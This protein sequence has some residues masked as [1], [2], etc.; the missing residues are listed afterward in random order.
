MEETLKD[1]HK[2]SA[3][4][5]AAL[6][7]SKEISSTELTQA[8]LARIRER[9]P[10][11]RAWRHID[12]DLALR[13]AAAADKAAARTPL[14]GIP[15]GVKDVIDTQDL[16]TEYGS[17]VHLGR[18][19]KA[20]AVCVAR[21]RAAGA[22]LLGKL[23]TTEY[24]FYT[25]NET[26]H[27]L[28]LAHTPG[29]SSSGTAASV[30]DMQVPIALGSQTAGSLIRP[31]AFCGVL[32]L[33]PTHGLVDVAGMLPLQPFFDTVGYMAR[34]VDDLRAFLGV[35]SGT[36]QLAEWPR[37][38]T[39]RI[40]LCRTHHWDRAEP[41]SRYV[42]EQTARQLAAQGVDIAEF[43]LPPAYADLPETHRIVSWKGVAQSLDADYRA[44][45]A[46]MSPRLASIIET[47]TAI[48]DEVYAGQLKFAKACRQGI[49][50]LLGD[51]DAVICPSAPG[52][53]PAGFGT[54]D[55]IFQ[56][57]WTLLGVPVVNLPVAT[58]PNRLPLGVQLIGKR[59]ADAN[60]LALADYIMRRTSH[61]TMA[62]VCSA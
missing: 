42:L 39:P 35:A 20:D 26:R 2:L 32:G 45:K 57:T 9:N 40:G 37:G 62:G 56:V 12:D 28:N 54:G 7:A 36:S 33:K 50:D 21:M 47:G 38:R 51:L 53:A 31:A 52:E 49:N 46:K 5:A 29:G 41:E 17:R 24:A 34:S 3:T 55:P 15:F 43:E 10:D 44:A 25:P 61:I 60:L 14:H 16:P 23:V 58:G 13:Q 19:P 4:Q 11:V 6:I 59:H 30:A 27:P 8:C 48:G 22:V 1:L 18:R